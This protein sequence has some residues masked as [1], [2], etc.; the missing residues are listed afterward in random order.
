MQADAESRA[1]I[2]ARDVAKNARTQLGQVDFELRAMARQAVEE[3][4]AKLEGGLLQSVFSTASD[5]L[6][7]SSVFRHHRGRVLFPILPFLLHFFVAW[8]VSFVVFRSMRSSPQSCLLRRAP[9]VL[10]SEVQISNMQ[11]LFRMQ[12]C[13]HNVPLTIVPAWAL[14]S[15]E[16][17][18]SFA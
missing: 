1:E 13:H 12:P 4:D 9:P 16:G 15:Q 14:G 11:T 3:V 7:V 10:V 5:V 6:S 17:L 2:A 18:I 8:K